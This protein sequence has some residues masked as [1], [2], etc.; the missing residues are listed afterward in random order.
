MTNKEVVIGID[1]SCYTTS[2]AVL[3]LEGNLIADERQILSVK[4][5]GCGLAQSEMVFQHT[6][7]LPVLM[8]II[9]FANLKVVGVG[10]TSRPRPLAESYM[11]AFLT[12]YGLAQNLAKVLNVSSFPLSHQ[13]N[14]LLAGMWS[15]QG[16]ENFPFLMLHASGGTTDLLLVKK[17]AEDKLTL[18][19]VGESI[20]LHAGQFVDRVGVALGLSFPAGPHLE[21][22]AETTDTPLELPIW[23]RG[24]K[25]SF[26]GVCTKAVRMAEAGADKAS[27]ALGVEV[28]IGKGL[29][30]LMVNICKEHDVHD[31]LIVGGVCANKYIRNL[32]TTNLQKNKIKTYMPEARFSGDGAVGAAYY[33]LL[34]VRSKLNGKGIY[35]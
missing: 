22:L 30:K 35:C 23:V 16:P 12:G 25:I 11:P 29:S 10:A 14:H 31:V 5:G 7:N 4:Q 28:V 34:E 1:T 33:A 17:D 8:S 32:V 13:E 2:V 20:D 9:D 3:D 18:E 26:S 21:A 27:L 15:A 24:N 19:T 6:R